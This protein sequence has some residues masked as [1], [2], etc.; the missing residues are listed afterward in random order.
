MESWNVTEEITINDKVSLGT[1]QNLMLQFDMKSIKFSSK[2]EGNKEGQKDVFKLTFQQIFLLLISLLL[3]TLLASIGNFNFPLARN[4]GYLLC[5]HG[6][7][8][9]KT[10]A[11][12]VET[13][14]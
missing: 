4:S 1:D 11:C 8:V 3:R 9:L 12:V 2:E 7:E 10:Y 5:M 14:Y 13:Q 6:W